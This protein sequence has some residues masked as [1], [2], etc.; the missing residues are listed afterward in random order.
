MKLGDK[1]KAAGLATMEPDRFKE[2]LV[3]TWDAM[4][5]GRTD[6]WVL[7]RPT[8]QAIP[9]CVA[10]RRK[11]REPDLPESVILETLM[12]LRKYKP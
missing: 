8:D 7:A 4:F 3:D 11:V 12:N 1:L 6:E 2:I 5:R 10:V 9:F